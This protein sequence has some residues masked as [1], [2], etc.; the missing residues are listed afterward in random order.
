MLKE[1]IG[2]WLEHPRLTPGGLARLVVFLLIAASLWAFAEIAGEVIAGDSLEF[3]RSVL[4]ALRTPGDLGDPLGPLWFEHAVR[5]I[6]ALGGTV[7]LALITIAVVGFLMI[8]RKRRTIAFLLLAVLG[9]TLLTPLLKAGFDRP[10]PDF[11]PHGQFVDSGS[12]P[13]GH[14]MN[15]AIVYL[16]LGTILAQAHRSRS[17]KIYVISAAI[18]ITA[19]VGLSRIYLGVHYPTDVLAGWTLGA[20][21]ALL[22]WLLI[23]IMQKKK[24]VEGEA[25]EEMPV[26]ESEAHGS[27]P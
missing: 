13:S 15:A 20:G 17:V 22:C 14:S 2:V 7:V 6:T 16:V 1:R 10:R 19:L 26:E 23:E 4:M 27:S 12:F 5:D 8:E 11:I 21:W 24:V 3:D 9:G 25:G 18:V